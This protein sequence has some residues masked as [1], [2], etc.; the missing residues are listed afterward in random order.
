MPPIRRLIG[1]YTKLPCSIFRIRE[2]VEL[3]MRP[4]KAPIFD[5]VPKNGLIYP[6]PDD[7]IFHGFCSAGLSSCI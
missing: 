5:Y 1:R 7:G 2:N 6:S 3:Q 4:K